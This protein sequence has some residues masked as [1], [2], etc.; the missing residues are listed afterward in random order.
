MFNFI[1]LKFIALGII[2]F[3]GPPGTFSLYR[4]ADRP[5]PSDCSADQHFFIR[6]FC[7][8]ALI[9][10]L[11]ADRRFPWLFRHTA[12]EGNRDATPPRIT[13]PEKAFTRPPCNMNTAKEEVFALPNVVVRILPGQFIQFVC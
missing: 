7:R 13:G 11:S 6:L 2:Y 10:R 12:R 5:F 9:I 4:S 8:S 1:S 3:P